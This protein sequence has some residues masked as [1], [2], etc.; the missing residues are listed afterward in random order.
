MEML[1]LVVP[2]LGKCVVLFRSA[3][4]SKMVLFHVHKDAACLGCCVVL[5]LVGYYT[6]LCLCDEKCS[7]I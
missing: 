1:V 4:A 2:G 7:T 5:A 3:S 6:M